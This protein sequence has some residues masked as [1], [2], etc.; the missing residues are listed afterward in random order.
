MK[1]K[2]KAL[3][4][5]TMLAA[6]I[7]F[8]LGAFQAQPAK[9]DAEPTPTPALH[10][11]A[12]PA[13]EAALHDISG[14]DSSATPTPT[15]EPTDKVRHH[16]HIDDNKVSVGDSTL[17]GQDESVDGNAVA[18]FGHLTVDGSVS[19]NSV[20]VMGS[21][22]I[23]GTVNGNAVAVFGDVTLGPKARL[24]GNAVAVGGRVIKDPSAFIGGNIVEPPPRFSFSDNG[25]ASSWWKHGLRMGR[26]LAIG[27]HLHLFWL[28]SAFTIALY[29]F[30]ALLFPGGVRK[31][32][33]T[34]ERRPGITFLTGFLAMLGLPVLFIL[35]CITVV[36]I[37]VALVVLP[38]TIMGCVIFGRTALYSL[39]GRLIVGR[40]VH[41]VL[42]V[43]V[44]VAIFVALYLVPVLGLMVWFLVTFL[45][46]ACALTTLFTSTKSAP[47]AG[48][49]QAGAP[50]AQPGPAPVAVV[51][52][53]IAQ[54]PMP[55]GAPLSA[56]A[57]PVV[58]A[59]VAPVPPPVYP[60]SESGLPRAGFWFRMVALLIDVILIGII[61]RSH[62]VILPALAIYGA[63]LWKLKGSTVGGIIF[64]LKVVRHDGR[65]L[66]WATSVVR[67][68]ACF[69]SLI[70]L[71]LGFIW[72]AFDPEKQGWHDKIAGTVVVR[73][74]RGVSL[75]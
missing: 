38:L 8:A 70:F 53:A 48:T 54:V 19:G 26:P 1:T 13:P 20:S 72:I 11:A 3:W 25:T 4:A 47:P 66:D 39:V 9:P 2:S 5:G 57:P 73:L 65:P 6:L 32:A 12:A 61:F 15:A 43:L 16:R 55:D 41:P 21:T 56:E 42:A 29:L 59:P 75:V 35:L 36:G 37:P 7:P 31:C 34:L 49:P 50:P 71:C 58:S 46:F 60:M 24:D 69:L 74:P 62:T 45:G 10:E 63:V 28:F 30:L 51:A 40:Q 44:G 33:D 67:A 52:P 17:V 23:N 68:L 22:T 27:P 18:V 14:N 64:G